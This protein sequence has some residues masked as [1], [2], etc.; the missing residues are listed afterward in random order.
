MEPILVAGAGHAGMQLADSLRAEGFSAPITLVNNEIGMPYQRPPLSKD[1][2]TAGSNP[3]Y[4][5]LKSWKFFIDNDIELIEGD[6]IIGIDRSRR[7]VQLAN[8]NTLTYSDLV[9]ATGARNRTLGV[10]GV[11]LEGVHYLRTATDAAR[12]HSA[13]VDAETTVVVGAGFIGLEF[14]AVARARGLDVTVIEH[15]SRPM[16]RAVSE[17]M[18]RFFADAH[19]AAGIQFVF[20]EDVTAL[21]GDGS[22]VSG[23]LTRSG[24][25]YKADLVLIGIGVEPNTELATTAD[26]TT[27]R[28]IDV[29]TYLRTDDEHIWAIGDCTYF[30]CRFAERQTRRESVQNAVDQARALA[31]TLTGIPTEY[32]EVPWF[33]S[34]QG[35]HKLQIAGLANHSDSTVIHGDPLSGKFSIFCFR[36]DSLTCVES[37]NSPGVHIAARRVLA[38]GALPS[39]SDVTADGFDLKDYA[40]RIPAV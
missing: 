13:L 2:L 18:S 3:Q 23:V 19:S 34:H 28:G 21:D 36:A 40:K 22:Q 7:S 4:L 24:K 25:R 1:F 32:L 30:P 6:P 35:T 29:D 15:G 33:W 12:L 31:R 27:T 16:A 20:N 38:S 39:V 37:I 26:L 17:E 9:L 14:A 5:P 10:A 11:E 8:G